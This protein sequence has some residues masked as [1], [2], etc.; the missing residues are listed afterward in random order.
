MYVVRV[1]YTPERFTRLAVEAA[2]ANSI[3]SL[4]DR[5]G[6]VQDVF[7]LAQAGYTKLSNALTLVWKWKNEP[8]R[9]YSLAQIA[10]VHSDLCI[11]RAR[12]ACH[13]QQPR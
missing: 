7:A 3:F 4:E 13:P 9:K 6:L 12:V 10:S 1:L 2:E 5:I 11:R 8:E